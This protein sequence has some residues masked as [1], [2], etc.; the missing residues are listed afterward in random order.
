MTKLYIYEKN[1]LMVGLI[2]EQ[3]TY[4][5]NGLIFG[6]IM[7]MNEIIDDRINGWMYG[8]MDEWKNRYMDEWGN[9]WIGGCT[10]LF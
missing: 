10:Q 7:N 6:C 8:W 9:E 2:V 1:L 4:L 3:M 5:T